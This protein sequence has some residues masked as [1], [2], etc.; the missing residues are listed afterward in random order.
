ME[1][2]DPKIGDPVPF[3]KDKRV[4]LIFLQP[5]TAHY[6]SMRL[7]AANDS[8]RFIKLN[9]NRYHTSLSIV[10]KHSDCASN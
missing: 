7:S 5:F 2:N 4:A 10:G 6:E 8:D 3:V 1:T 9:T